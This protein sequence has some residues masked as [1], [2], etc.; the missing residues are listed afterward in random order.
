MRACMWGEWGRVRGRANGP[1]T[2]GARGPS[3]GPDAPDGRRRAS[4]SSG[5]SRA[6][7]S[8]TRAS[9]LSRGPSST[10]DVCLVAFVSYTMCDRARE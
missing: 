8:S 10:A 3:P 1:S 5:T 9:L 6:V 7:S 2:S 4:S